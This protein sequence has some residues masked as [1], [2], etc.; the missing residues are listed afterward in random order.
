M[1]SHMGLHHNLNMDMK[2]DAYE[3]IS[4]YWTNTAHSM[5]EQHQIICA[6]ENMSIIKERSFSP[7]LCPKKGIKRVF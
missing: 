4:V 1:L 6:F 7:V 3:D 2:H 5:N